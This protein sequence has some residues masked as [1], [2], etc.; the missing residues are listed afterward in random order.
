[1]F[2]VKNYG[3]SSCVAKNMYKMS[4]SCVR[5]YGCFSKWFLLENALKK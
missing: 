1:M 4:G 5:N 3:K 2:L